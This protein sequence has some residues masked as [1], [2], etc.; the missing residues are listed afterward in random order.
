M[1]E[2]KHLKIEIVWISSHAEID[3][4]KNANAEAKKAAKDSTL[5]QAY[6]Y[7]PLKSARTRYIK[8]IMK[9]Q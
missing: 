1:N 4:N 5:S 8:A 7:K 2:H 3:G 9:K 6:N